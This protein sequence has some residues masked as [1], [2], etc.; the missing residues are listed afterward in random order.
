MDETYLLLFAI[1]GV[2]SLLVI[3][4]TYHIYKLTKIE[5]TTYNLMDMQEFADLHPMIKEL[6]KEAVVN[7]VHYIQNMIITDIIKMNDIDKWYNSNKADIKELIRLVKEIDMKRHKDKNLK[8]SS[9][10]MSKLITMDIKSIIT[11]MKEKSK[12]DEDDINDVV[13]VIDNTK[14]LIM[15][16]LDVKS[17]FK[18][19]ST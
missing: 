2:L 17:P 19:S 10:E 16:K 7:G 13:D 18:S 4:N 14:T 1:V 8:I 6:Y 5:T 15:D 3:T 12:Y 9:S 11:Y